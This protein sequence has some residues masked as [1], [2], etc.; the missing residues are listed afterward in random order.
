LNEFEKG[1]N[2]SP[3]RNEYNFR[4]LKENSIILFYLT[5]T[6]K[7]IL[8]KENGELRWKRLCVA[9]YRAI[10]IGI[11]FKSNDDKETLYERAER[12]E[13]AVKYVLEYLPKESFIWANRLKINFYEILSA[14]RNA[15]QKE[16]K[17]KNQDEERVSPITLNNYRRVAN[18]LLRDKKYRWRRYYNRRNIQSKN[19]NLELNNKF[20]DDLDYE[21]NDPLKGLFD[22]TVTNLQEVEITEGGIAEE[23]DFPEYT[24]KL[25]NSPKGS[26]NFS[27]GIRPIGID[28][29]WSKGHLTAEVLG[30]LLASLEQNVLKNSHQI[31]NHFVLLFVQFQL[32]F[33]FHPEILI[34]LRTESFDENSVLKL[35]KN[36][37]IIKPKRE[38]S[39]EVFSSPF[40]DVRKNLHL[41]SEKSEMV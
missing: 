30:T 37:L 5:D 36:K 31:Y 32:Y 7:K 35:D 27:F 24:P 8:N 26:A 21:N 34:N 3:T 6:K 38:N 1:L 29:I 18:Y 15:H 20:Q 9:G 14:I 22:K 39:E 25:R 28:P 17:K 13:I 41:E 12:S 4:I 16:R 33:G 11:D 23:F 40:N 2:F 19:V 10:R